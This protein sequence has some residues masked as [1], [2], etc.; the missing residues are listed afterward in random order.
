[1]NGASIGNGL[2]GCGKN[3]EFRSNVWSGPA[4]LGLRSLEVERKK[5][6]AGRDNAGNEKDEECAGVNS[7]REVEGKEWKVGEIVRVRRRG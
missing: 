1:M 6:S 5:G 7:I 3:S 2:G 4:W